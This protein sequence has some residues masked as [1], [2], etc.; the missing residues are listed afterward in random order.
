MKRIA[1]GFKLKVTSAIADFLAVANWFNA[2]QI[3]L[4]NAHHNQALGISA[5]D[6]RY[7]GRCS[8]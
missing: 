6:S 2:F 4:R 8:I 3:L 5:S 1:H 7:D